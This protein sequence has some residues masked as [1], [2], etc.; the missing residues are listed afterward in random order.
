MIIFVVKHSF[1]LLTISMQQ[2]R[3]ENQLGLQRKIREKRHS[4][5]CVGFSGG[6]VVKYLPANEGDTALISG[7]ER[8][9]GE[10]NGKPLQDSCL[11]NSMDRGTWQ[12]RVHGVAEQDTTGS[13]RDYVK[14]DTSVLGIQK[15]T[16][17]K[18]INVVKFKP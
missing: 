7:W 10:G 15:F 13:T 6:S 17:V 8:F 12:D 5:G 14:S 1:H 9:P 2:S 4:R 3:T 18:P 16:S 11:E